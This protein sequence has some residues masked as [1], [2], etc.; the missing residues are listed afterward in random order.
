MNTRNIALDSIRW[1]L[2]IV[3]VMHHIFV[4]FYNNVP[5]IR[6]LYGGHLAVHPL[7]E[8][9]RKNISFLIYAFS[10]S[11]SHYRKSFKIL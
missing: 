6:Y 9:I 10:F 3:I 4:N 1:I 2:A 5:S 8:K 7:M 11:S